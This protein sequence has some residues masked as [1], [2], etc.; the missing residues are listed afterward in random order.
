MGQLELEFVFILEP[1]A[2]GVELPG[3]HIGFDCFVARQPQ[4][5]DRHRHIHLAQRIDRHVARRLW[6]DRAFDV[7]RAFR[8]KLTC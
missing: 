2:P 3:T 4:W 5:P 8:R 6:L 1:L 7:R